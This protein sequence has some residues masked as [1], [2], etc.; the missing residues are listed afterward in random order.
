MTNNDYVEKLYKREKDLYKICFYFGL[1]EI[2]AQDIIQDLYVKL[3]GFRFIDKYIFNDEPNMSFIFVVLKNIIFDYKKTR[4]KIVYQDIDGIDI[5]DDIKELSE[6]TIW[7][8]EEIEKLNKFDQRIIYT[9]IFEDLTV[10][11]LG[12][13]FNMN[14]SVIQSSITYFKNRCRDNFLKQK[15]NKSVII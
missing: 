7:L 14:F 15:L 5:I 4:K 10:R 3:L 6:K 9:R 8:F 11:K 13:R 1:N 2:D 12:E